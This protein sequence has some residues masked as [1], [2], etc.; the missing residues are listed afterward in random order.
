MT[1][2]RYT[3]PITINNKIIGTKLP[4]VHPF[5]DATY[6]FTKANERLRKN[7]ADSGHI[8]PN[9][10]VNNCSECCMAEI[11][12]RPNIKGMQFRKSRKG[13]GCWQYPV[14][15]GANHLPARMADGTIIRGMSAADLTLLEIDESE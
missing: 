3:E 7:P 8:E 2:Q 14:A 15:M 9:A 1:D 6:D 12:G 10:I 13:K 4:E 5:E 11:N